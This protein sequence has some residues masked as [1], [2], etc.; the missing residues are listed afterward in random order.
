[1]SIFEASKEVGLPFKCPTCG[2]AIDVGEGIE[3]CDHVEFVWCWGDP[4]FWVFA[5]FK[6]RK[7]YIDLLRK[8]S[9]TCDDDENEIED[10]IIESFVAESFEPLDDVSSAIPFNGGIVEELADTNGILMFEN[11]GYYS[12]VVI[13]IKT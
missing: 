6:F 12:G 11:S 1:M 3:Y 2:K 7:Q 13:G 8:K 10:K 4:D 9:G 5:K